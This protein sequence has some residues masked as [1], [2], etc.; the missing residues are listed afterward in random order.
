MFVNYYP[1]GLQFSK[2]FTHIVD[3]I[4]YVDKQGLKEFKKSPN[5]DVRHFGEH[6]AENNQHAIIEKLLKKPRDMLL[7]SSLP[8]LAHTD[9]VA[10]AIMIIVEDKL[11]DS[12][13]GMENNRIALWVLGTYSNHIVT[14]PVGF[15]EDRIGLDVI[16][17]AINALDI[18]DGVVVRSD[19]DYYK[20]L[21]HRILISFND[22]KHTKAY[23]LNKFK[24][25]TSTTKPKS[26]GGDVGSN[27]N[28]DNTEEPEPTETS[29]EMNMRQINKEQ[30]ML[31]WLLGCSLVGIVAFVI[32]IS[33]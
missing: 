27:A 12:L 2:Y 3:N 31:D 29:Q 19:N 21:T 32:C 22:D 20:S 23:R 33:L 10:K 28:D 11:F 6:H 16:M 30:R 18:E 17:D 1:Y 25:D 13:S 24:P 15:C 9:P 14:E 8:K 7:N 5:R 26:I 4:Y